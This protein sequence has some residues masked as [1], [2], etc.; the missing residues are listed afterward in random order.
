MGVTP[1]IGAAGL[2]MEP[3]PRFN[4]GGDAEDRAIATFDNSA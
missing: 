4:P 2:G 1:L 3:N